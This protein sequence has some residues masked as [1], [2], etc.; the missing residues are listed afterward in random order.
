MLVG[1]KV[2]FQLQITITTGSNDLDVE[3]FSPDDNYTAMA[4]CSPMV[5]FVGS[6]IAYTA[7]T[8]VPVTNTMDNFNVSD[9]ICYFCVKLHLR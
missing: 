5:T 9:F 3:L 2:R 8:L 7:T 6:N 1:Q 4:I